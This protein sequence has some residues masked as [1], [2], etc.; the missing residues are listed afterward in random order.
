M[1]RKYGGNQKKMKLAGVLGK[2]ITGLALGM[3]VAGC[4]SK[5]D[6]SYKYDTNG[7]GR[8]GLEEAVTYYNSM[9]PLED[10]INLHGGEISNEQLITLRNFYSE[11]SRKE[12]P[13]KDSGRPFSEI[14]KEIN[15]YL[16]FREEL[17]RV[18][19]KEVESYEQ[20]QLKTV[21]V[22]K[23]FDRPVTEEEIEKVLRDKG[24]DFVSAERVET[25][26]NTF[27]IKYNYPEETEDPLMKIGVILRDWD[28]E[29]M[30]KRK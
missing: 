10:T 13:P 23:M 26:E 5:P 21:S 15:A 3:S 12:N 14:V 19:M 27:R 16:R 22:A 24:I 29:E 11:Q 9:V 20:K 7:D 18:G 1:A 6:L 2:I 30:D 25:E 28:F 8:F 17:S 4:G